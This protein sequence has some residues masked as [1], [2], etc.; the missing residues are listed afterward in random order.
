[1]AKFRLFHLAILVGLLGVLVSLYRGSTKTQHPP[2]VIGNNNT[3][4]FAVNVEYGLSNVHLA[5]IFSLLQNHPTISIHVASFPKLAPKL[6]RV[7]NYAR[8]N[9]PGM[10][11]VRFHELPGPDLV[12]ASNRTSIDLMQPPGISGM[13]ALMKDLQRYIAPWT[14]SDYLQIHDYSRDLIR[15]VD[16]AVIV[17]DGML[18]PAVDAARGEKRLYAM[19]APN[20]LAD[21][22]GMEQPWLAGLWKYPVL[23]SGYDFPVPWR[24]IPANIYQAARFAYNMFFSPKL[25]A[26]RKYLVENGVKDPID[27][28]APRQ[29]YMGSFILQETQGASLPVDYVPPNIVMAGPISISVAT[30]EEL[31]PE[32]TAWLSR[33]PTVLVNLGSILEYD[34]DRAAAM[35]GALK[36]MLERTGVQVLWKLLPPADRV[37]VEDAWRPLVEE[38]IH[39]DRLRVTKWLS[40]EPLALLQTGY[41]VVSVHQ[42]GASC[43]HEAVLAGVPHIVLPAWADL[44]NYASL[45]ETTDIGVWGNRKAAPGISA[46]ELGSAFLKMVDGGPASLSMRENAKR[47]GKSIV[48]PGRDIAADE[49]ARLAATGY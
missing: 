49:V 19:L 45:A 10:H 9:Y 28:L 32:L 15:D 18:W 22:F 2:P 5:T 41:I 48:R 42:G 34:E 36:I 26:K 17:L 6:E 46:D 21:F 31:D 39:S 25:A 40:V 30:A 44:Y 43:Y 37:L 7:A 8:K 24:D 13:D 27:F 12:T 11:V 47:L 3:V 33:A 38:F 1:M 35:A 29:P 4:L 20:N 23:G 16:P 14:E